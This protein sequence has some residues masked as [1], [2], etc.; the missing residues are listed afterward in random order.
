MKRS[1]KRIIV[2]SG[3]DGP[4]IE[5]IKPTSLSEAFLSPA[6]SFDEIGKPF[7]ENMEEVKA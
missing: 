4:N 1:R 5:Q 6:Q 7:A 2:P 3:D